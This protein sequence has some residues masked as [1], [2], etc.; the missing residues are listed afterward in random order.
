MIVKCYKVN[1][2]TLESKPAPL[3]SLSS[4]ESFKNSLQIAET[5]IG[6]LKKSATEQEAKAEASSRMLV[7]QSKVESDLQKQASVRP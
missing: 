3:I 4:W 1:Y 2:V 5:T 6:E 7:M